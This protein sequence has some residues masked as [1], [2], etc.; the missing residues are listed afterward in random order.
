MLI[1]MKDIKG[2]IIITPMDI[3]VSQLQRKF[4]GKTL[5]DFALESFERTCKDMRKHMK[6]E[7]KR[8]R[9]R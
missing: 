3:W 1:K 7:L 6:K 4:D 9:C 8:A 2:S 5:Y